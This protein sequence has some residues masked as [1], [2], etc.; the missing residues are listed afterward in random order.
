MN[1]K[2]ISL[3]ILSAI[4]LTTLAVAEVFESN[5]LFDGDT[6]EELT[7]V[8]AI[9]YVCQDESC[10]TATR[11]WENTMN[12]GN[13]NLIVL[14]YPTTLETE[15][16]YMTY[17]FKSGYVPTKVPA[18]WAGK[19]NTEEYDNFLYKIQDTA[20]A[21]IEDFEVNDKTAKINQEI[22]ITANVLSPR[23]NSDDVKFIPEELIED[24]YSDKVRTTLKIKNQR[25]GGL[26]IRVINE[27]MLWSTEDKVEFTWTPVEEGDY[28]VEIYTE[29]ADSKFLNTENQKTQKIEV[30]VK[31]TQDPDDNDDD[32]ENKYPTGFKDLIDTTLED[33][34]Y[35]N[36]YNQINQLDE[37]D[38]E[39]KDSNWEW[40]LSAVIILIVLILIIIGMILGRDY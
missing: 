13:D 11:L 7:D 3:F 32:T 24:Y 27:K 22:T 26:Y 37:E 4:L 16:G 6:G 28:S 25:T 34:Q 35:E 30:T 29:V 2:T 20:S 38:L 17:F 31:G 19:G 15:F 21:F 12:T 9:M 8:S 23:I 10:G 1:S 5:Y 33:E 39:D 40:Y 18:D 14:T 36:Q